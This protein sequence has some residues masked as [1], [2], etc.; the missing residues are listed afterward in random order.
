MS[1]VLSRAAL[2]LVLDAFGQ[3]RGRGGCWRGRNRYFAG[4][5]CAWLRQAI[6]HDLVPGRFL[7]PVAARRIRN[8][9]PIANLGETVA[10]NAV[11]QRKLAHRGC[12]NLTVEVVSGHGDW[13]FCAFARHGF[14]P[15]QDC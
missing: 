1:L 8:P 11:M 15:L 7:G 4:C 6:L 10:G 2:E 5:V 3:L 13:L 9:E 12:P 14:T